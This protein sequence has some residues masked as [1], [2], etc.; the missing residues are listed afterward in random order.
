MEDK[1]RES[2]TPKWVIILR[3]ALKEAIEKEKKEK[4]SAQ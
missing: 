4:K 1:K 2:N 3:E